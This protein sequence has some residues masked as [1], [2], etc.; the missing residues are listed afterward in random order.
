[1]V[2]GEL[3]WHSLINQQ[4]SAAEDAKRE[5]QCTLGGC[6]CRLVQPQWKTVWNFLKKL[7]VELPFDP[8]IHLLGIPYFSDRKM[9]LG[10]R[11]GKQEKKIEAK[12][13]VKYLIT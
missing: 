12:N 6:E 11:G 3:D 8:A 9:H 2:L 7:K 10:F 4:T 1:M 5:W 13:V